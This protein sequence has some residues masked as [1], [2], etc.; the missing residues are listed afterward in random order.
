M[1]KNLENN[2]C[3]D[4]ITKK[5]LKNDINDYSIISLAF[6]GDAVWS[7]FVRDKLVRSKTSKVNELHKCTT[8][9][10]KA[11]S[12]SFILT[13]LNLTESESELIRRARNTKTNNKA[14]NSSEKDYK[15]ATAF[16]AL[17][18]YLNLT[19]N[20]KRLNLILNISYD[21][22]NKELLNGEE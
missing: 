9:F 22:I 14:K 3:F 12:Q 6:V 13:K 1:E 19:E 8:K 16:E 21:I 10:V 18:G 4:A 7:Y 20:Y 17:L 11:T 2:N 5:A 15:L